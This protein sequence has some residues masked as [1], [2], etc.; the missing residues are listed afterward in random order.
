MS[1]AVFAKKIFFYYFILLLNLRRFLTLSVADVLAMNG[2]GMN[3][4]MMCEFFYS[5]LFS[6]EKKS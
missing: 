6:K 5:L 2:A 3:Y 1:M 4:L